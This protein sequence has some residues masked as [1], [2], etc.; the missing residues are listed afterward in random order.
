M[1]KTLIFAD[2]HLQAGNPAQIREFATWLRQFN[3]GD[4]DRVVCVG[5]LFDFWFEYRHV[6]FSDYFEV[7][8]AFAEMRD[9]GVEL[10]LIC[11]NH[12]F[13]GGRFLEEELGL[14]IHL[15]VELPFGER[16]VRFIHGDGINP[17]DWKY[18]LYKRIARNP[19][20]VWCF[21]QLHPDWAMAIARGV[22]HGSRTLYKVDDPSTGAEAHAL[23]AY[24]EGVLERGEADAV[25]CGHS[26]A[27]A[28]E[29][30]PHPAGE[31]I[32][33]NPGDWFERR[34]YALWDGE[35]FTL[36]DTQPR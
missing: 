13:W 20:V 14:Q 16:T 2:V 22:S 23:R 3:H 1:K 29:R 19:F 10:H 17:N 21:R 24:A 8:R 26:H 4:F 7:L 32:Y 12:D 18:R 33:L 5:D 28:M 36:C 31:G 34:Q 35:H 15:Q 9:A 27:A 30:H 11:G 6:I 25:C